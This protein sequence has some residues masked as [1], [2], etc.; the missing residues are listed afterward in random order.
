MSEKVFLNKAY[1]DFE[2]QNKVKVDTKKLQ[3]LKVE[4]IMVDS[5]LRT[6]VRVSTD[7]LFRGNILEFPII[8]II[9]NDHFV[10]ITGLIVGKVYSGLVLNLEYIGGNKLYLLEDFNVEVGD[11]ISEYI[12]K[13]YKLA[14]NREVTEEEFNEW[15]FRLQRESYAI[16][17]FI[18]DIVSSDEFYEVNKEIDFFIKVLYEIIFRREIDDETFNYWKEKYNDKILEETDG[19]VRQYII[20]QMMYYKQFEYLL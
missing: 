9:I 4:N 14:L 7:G 20:N 6:C 2:F 18:I 1:G 10:E 13:T 8:D 5:K 16:N 15:Y 19:E 12:C 3:V 17:D 11:V